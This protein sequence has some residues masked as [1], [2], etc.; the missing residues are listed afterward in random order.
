MAQGYGNSSIPV[1][2]K[3]GSAGLRSESA[4]DDTPGVGREGN[5]TPEGVEAVL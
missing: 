1:G 3:A 2:I 5:S 4:S